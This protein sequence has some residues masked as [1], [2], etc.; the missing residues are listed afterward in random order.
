[1]LYFGAPA[2]NYGCVDTHGRPLW[3]AQQ[4]RWLAW[5]AAREAL[6]GARAEYRRALLLAAERADEVGSHR[7]LDAIER[8]LLGEVVTGGT[9]P[10]RARFWRFVRL[11]ARGIT[12]RDLREQPAPIRGAWSVDWPDVL[13]DNSLSAAQAQVARLRARA[14]AA[15]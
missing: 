15:A 7:A 4:H 11:Q 2:S 14:D 10:K 6:R 5:E 13:G 9:F 3:D 12:P 1:M 8:R